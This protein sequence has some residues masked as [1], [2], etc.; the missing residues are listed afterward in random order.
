V[1]EVSGEDLEE[2]KQQDEKN[3]CEENN[4]DRL[5]DHYLPALILN[6][7]NYNINFNFINT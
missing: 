1:C 3:D 4:L 2:L 7:T 5:E 6:I